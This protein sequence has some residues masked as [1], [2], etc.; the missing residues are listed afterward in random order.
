MTAVPAPD[1]PIDIRDPSSPLY[2]RVDGAVGRLLINRADKRNALSQAMWEAVPVALDLLEAEAGVHVIILG[3]AVDGIFCAGADL[4]ELKAIAGD[5]DRCEA[6]RRAIRAAQQRLLYSPKPVIAA[7]PGACVGGGCGLALHADLRVASRRA[8]F[9]ITPAK[10][11]LVYPLSDTRRVVELAGVAG[12][13]RLLLTAALIPADEAK[14]M[15]LVDF[16]YEDDDF[17]GAVADLAD[18]IAGLSPFSLKAVKA[19]IRSVANGQLDEDAESIRLF[20]EAHTGPDATEGIAAFLDKRT[21][22]FTS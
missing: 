2:I 3:S 17:D 21:P 6:N 11:G 20:L 9:G 8:R 1:R 22:R 15:G 5:A 12:A 19:T 4:A 10:I 18:K 7:I 14:S 13:S 16:V